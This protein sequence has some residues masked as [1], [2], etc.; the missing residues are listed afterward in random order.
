MNAPVA[1]VLM[2]VP[3]TAIFTLPK[4]PANTQVATAVQPGPLAILSPRSGSLPRR[5]SGSPVGDLDPVG[6]CLPVGVGHRAELAMAFRTDLCAERAGTAE[7]L[8]GKRHGP[9]LSYAPGDKARR[10]DVLG[11]RGNAVAT[12]GGLPMT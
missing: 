1:P 3:A 4:A 12:G 6:R 11:G 8:N 10:G 7:T 9:V 2:I 5:C